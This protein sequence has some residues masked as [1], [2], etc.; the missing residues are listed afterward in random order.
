[1][2]TCA[3]GPI[4][5]HAVGTASTPVGAEAVEALDSRQ[6]GCPLTLIHIFLTGS[7]YTESQRQTDIITT[8]DTKPDI[9]S[10]LLQQVALTPTKTESQGLSQ[11]HRQ[12][13]KKPRSEPSS[14]T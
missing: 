5:Q 6:A 8:D 13:D 10:P 7:A 12:R 1:M 9:Q 4:S 14:E 2:P 11:A 3:G